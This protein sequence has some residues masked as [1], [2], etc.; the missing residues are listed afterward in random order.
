MKIKKQN[1]HNFGRT[2]PNDLKPSK[3]DYTREMGSKYITLG[4][5]FKLFH[6]SENFIP[7]SGLRISSSLRIFQYTQ[8]CIYWKILKGLGTLRGYPQGENFRKTQKFQL[9]IKIYVFRLHF[10]SRIHFRRFQ[11][12]WRHPWKVMKNLNFREQY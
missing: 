7:G 1:F 3:I 11:G 4:Y 6:F 9:D 2:S 5:Q 10:V 8:M 12:I